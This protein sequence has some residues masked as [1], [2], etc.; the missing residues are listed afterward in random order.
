MSTA[1]LEVTTPSDPWGLRAIVARNLRKRRKELGY[2]Q[3]DVRDKLAERFGLEVA[4]TTYGHYERSHYPMNLDMLGSLAIIL[5][6]SP[7][8]LVTPTRTDG[9][10][11]G[12]P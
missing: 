3:E 2:R 1:P 10:S 11:H 12:H 6:T 5:E 7:S 4:I 9:A 8:A